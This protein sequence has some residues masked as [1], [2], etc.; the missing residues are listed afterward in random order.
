MTKAA[1]SIEIAVPDEVPPGWRRTTLGEIGEYIN[2]RGFKKPEW[3]DKGLPIIRIQNLTG[4]GKEQNYYDGEIDVRHVAN[5]GDLLISWAATLGAYLWT[6]PRAALNQ[7]IFK[8]RSFVDKKFHYYLMQHILGDLYRQT[9]GSGMVHI[10]K[11]KFDS[12]PIV[13]P[14]TEDQQKRIVAEI[15][16]Q[17]SHLDE[18]VADLR[19]VKA[20]LKRYKAAVLKAAV[21]G[22]LVETEASIARREKRT[23]ETGEQLLKRILETRRSRWLASAE[24]AGRK[25]K[26]KYKESAAPD[27]NALPELPEGWV[28]TSLDQLSWDS[29][30]GTSTKCA[31]DN[32]GPPVLRIP[33]VDKAA[34]DLADLKY[35]PPDL[36]VTQSEALSPGDMLIIRTNG[37]KSLI[38]RAAIVTPHFP[39]STTYASYLIRFRL[40]T[41][42]RSPDWVLTFWRSP[43]SRLWVESKA[44]TSA[45][46]HNISMSVL[47]TSPL[48]LPPVAEQ[49]RI[50]AEV[51]H[52]LSLIRETEAQ[53]DVN[54]KRGERLRQSVLH[55]VFSS[56]VIVR[57]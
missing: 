18:A 44:A 27:T 42:S 6:G 12:M 40:L 31:Y 7:H 39:K 2:G 4:T 3:S 46:Q 24:Q 9:H 13:V 20:N 19:R 32:K 56:G 43:S 15:E 57:R 1:E 10:T 14:E 41:D 47:A 22:R 34:I 48:P 25:D 55:T 26:R 52:R 51:D 37:S 45:G 29:S 38:G 5:P 53:V 8:V 16:K 11:S 36:V 28:W 54:I 33:N 35:G 17:F 49:I 50:V 30:Y 23:Y 21:E